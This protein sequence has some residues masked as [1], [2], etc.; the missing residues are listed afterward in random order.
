MTGYLHSDYSQSLSE[1]G[2][3][4][5]LPQ[6]G[7]WVLERSVDGCCCD[8]MGSYPLFAC[9]DWRELPSDLEAMG[10]RWVSLAVV[11]DPF[12]DYDEQ[13]LRTCFPDLVL[14]FKSHFVTDLDRSPDS[15]IAEHHQRNARKALERLQIERCERPEEL[16]EEWTRLY[17]VL[18]ARHN[19]RGI[20]RFSRRIFARQLLVPGIVAFRALDQ[21]SS[22]GVTL[23]YVQ[24]RVAYYHLG[25]YS[26]EGYELRASF[27]LFRRAIEYFSV[28]GLKWLDLGAGAGLDDSGTDGLSRFKRGWSTGTRRAYFCGRI[29]DREKYAL[30]AESRGICET[31]YFPAYRSGE[32]G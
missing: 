21:S 32:F 24:D 8:A 19:I 1:F 4:T 27:A 2:L 18:V 10:K 11:S 26:E 3:P 9:P 16:L 30:L 12:G 29:F 5:L 31:N 14:P 28:S 13:F 23:W 17:S 20:P 22:V 15:F 6:S 25:A 7:A